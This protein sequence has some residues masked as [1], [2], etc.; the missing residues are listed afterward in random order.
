MQEELTMTS[1]ADKLEDRT[2]EILG[3]IQASVA[4][5]VRT[6]NEAGA[7]RRRE[8]DEVHR[9]QDEAIRSLKAIQLQATA[10]AEAHS[11]LAARAGNDWLGLVE[12]GLQETAVAQ[13]EAAVRAS[14][15]Q[16]DMKL[17]ELTVVVRDA[18]D[19]VGQLADRNERI[20]RALA[21]K[22]VAVSAGWLVVA[23]IGLR[24]LVL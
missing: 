15:A 5:Y 20:C 16:I 18:V 3:Q 4:E 21:W 24:I 2:A 6:M 9:Q 23:A 10:I 22:T 1:N 11:R 19:K 17:F 7:L 12:R 13:A 14:V 8:A